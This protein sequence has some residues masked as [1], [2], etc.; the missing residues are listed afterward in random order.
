[1]A[2]WLLPVAAAAAAAATLSENAEGI[3]PALNL[4]PSPLPQHVPDGG[5][6]G[7]G[8]GKGYTRDATSPISAVQ[9]LITR[10]GLSASDFSLSMIAPTAD[11]LDTMQLASAG[12]KVAL[13]GS[14][15]VALASALNW[16]LN[17]YCN[18][19]YDW[20]TYNLAIPNTLPLPPVAGTAVR[21]RTVK[22]GY[23]MNVC[24]MG[25]SLVFTDWTYWEKQIDWMAMN[26]INLPLSFVGQEWIWVEVFKDYNLSWDDLAP[27]FTGPAFLPWYRMGNIRGFAG[28]DLDPSAE[29]NWVIE[30]GAFQKRLLARMRGLGMT[31]V[32]SAFSGHIPKALADQHPQAK[33]R[34]SPNWGH[35]PTDYNTEKI[36]HANYASVYMLDPHDALFTEIGNKFV[37]KMADEWGTDHIYQTDTYNEME[38]TE[39]D[40]AF[41]N[42]SSAAVYAAMTGADPDAIWLMQG[43]LFHESFWNPETTA[44][45]LGGVAK[46]KMWVLDLNTESRPIYTRNQG[47]G[48]YGHPYIWCSLNTYGGQ[49]G[50]YGPDVST[51]IFGATGESGVKA[52]LD[53][54]STISGVGITMEGIWTNYPV[55][56]STLLLGWEGGETQGCEKGGALAGEQPAPPPPTVPPHPALN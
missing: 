17:E 11:G 32:L 33:I 55:F 7:L 20:S 4:E 6:G 3:T 15:G 48:L 8:F 44:A 35:M 21:P 36:H 16:Y 30:R 31:A 51:S 19:T 39:N 54:N 46:E 25:Y 18:T 26:G 28:A 27:F 22:W 2:G 12:G 1:M 38:P 43:W 52:A 23:Y 42:A 45:Y 10:V 49:N 41:L 47:D 29:R 14:G 56:E 37:A 5:Y 53:S 50:L 34:R 9:A 13:R 24:T 40:T